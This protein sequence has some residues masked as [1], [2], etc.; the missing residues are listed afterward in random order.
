M[1]GDQF[2]NTGRELRTIVTTDRH[3][4]TPSWKSVEGG[5]AGRDGDGV[6]CGDQP[7]LPPVSFTVGPFGDQGYCS[8]FS[9]PHCH[10]HVR[11]PP[12]PPHLC[13]THSC[14]PSTFSPDLARLPLVQGPQVDA[15]S[16]RATPLYMLCGAPVWYPTM[17]ATHAK[18][19]RRV[20][21]PSRMK[22]PPVLYICTS[23]RMQTH[24]HMHNHKCRVSLRDRFT[25][26]S[27]GGST[28]RAL[29]YQLP[30]HH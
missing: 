25:G 3:T 21:I 13:V 2:N 14:T 28:R 30:P 8:Q 6:S 26:L 19:Q 27:H 17:H 7:L 29:F 11:A 4:T 22:E 20:T 24:R 9:L 10:H 16:T 1:T 23:T 5:G 12:T 18:L 15:S